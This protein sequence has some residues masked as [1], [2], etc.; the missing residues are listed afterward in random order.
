V[1]S[2]T[3][4][5]GMIRKQTRLAVVVHLYPRNRT[6][7]FK[8]PFRSSTQA[9]TIIF[10]VSLLHQPMSVRISLTSLIHLRILFATLSSR[11]GGV[12][13]A[14]AFFE[15]QKE[16]VRFVDL[17]I[18]NVGQREVICFNSTFCFCFSWHWILSAQRIVETFSRTACLL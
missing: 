12:W 16:L 11:D 7:R 9:S 10:S 14:L 1:I 4:C 13:I 17:Y 6:K 5:S 8:S 3:Q 15:H 2:Q 18:I